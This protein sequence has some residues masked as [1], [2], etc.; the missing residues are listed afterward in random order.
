LKE[1]PMK[2]MTSHMQQG[3]ALFVSLV[4]LLL[5]TIVGVAAMQNATLQEKMAGNTKL[6]NE[7][8][9][10]AEAGLREGEALVRNNTTIDACVATPEAQGP[11][12][13]AQV[14]AA[15][16]EGCDVWLASDDGNSHF[17]IQKLTTSGAA[18]GVPTGTSVTLFRV[19]AVATVGN[20]TSAVE[21]I[22]AKN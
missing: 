22:Y 8:F 9:Q 10:Y 20:S 2:S 6:K 18:R 12:I 17:Q 4:F 7:S 3:M 13:S 21:S 16:G 5:L 19:T 1:L 15:T 14:Q 11:D